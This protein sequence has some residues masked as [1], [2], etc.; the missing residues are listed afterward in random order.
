MLQGAEAVPV[1]PQ[2]TPR[3]AAKKGAEAADAGSLALGAFS[4]QP[5]TAAL[6]A[7]AKQSIAVTFNAQGAK[8][9]LQQVGI[10]VSDR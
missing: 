4:L 8:L 1:A 3:G 10:D 9:S 2:A 7:G 6:A 5:A